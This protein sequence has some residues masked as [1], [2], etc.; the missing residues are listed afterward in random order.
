VS[1]ADT[2]FPRICVDSA[3]NAVAVYQEK[4]SAS[5]PFQV[6]GRLWSGGAWSAPGRV[7]NNTNEGRFADCVKHESNSFLRDG[8]FVAWR[9]T[10]PSAAS[11]FRIVTATP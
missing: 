5:D 3:G 8:V 10:N 2:R 4:A 1:A 9:E 11:E 6:W 7:Q